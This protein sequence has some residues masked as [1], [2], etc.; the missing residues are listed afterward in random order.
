MFPLIDPRL[1]CDFHLVSKFDMHC[2]TAVGALITLRTA[3]TSHVGHGRTLP[4]MCVCVNLLWIC[5]A[6]SSWWS[7]GSLHNVAQLE[8]CSILYLVPLW[9]YKTLAS[10]TKKVGSTYTFYNKSWNTSA[11]HELFHVKSR[12]RTACWNV[13]SPQSSTQGE[14][15]HTS[16][17]HVAVLLSLWTG[18]SWEAAGSVFQVVS[19]LIVRSRL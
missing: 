4:Y 19:E 6:T 9:V 1:N 16:P 2:L 10:K 7:L 11:P 15:P 17:V 13:C 8:F 12:T 5:C 18:A 3:S 14:C